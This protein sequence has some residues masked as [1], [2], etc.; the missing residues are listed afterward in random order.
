MQRHLERAR[1]LVSRRAAVAGFRR[2]AL[3]DLVFAVIGVATNSIRHGGGAGTLRLWLDGDRLLCELR[4][5]G[6]F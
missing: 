6:H 3:A 1:A 4:D 2:S 5:T